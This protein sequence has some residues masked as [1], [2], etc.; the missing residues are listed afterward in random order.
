M[1]YVDDEWSIQQCVC[2]LMLLE[3][4][5]TGEEVARQIINTI[6]RELGMP[7]SSVIA[8][9]RDSASVNDVAMR[10]VLVE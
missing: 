7:S 6:S 10:T 1:Q 5:M 4:T 3:K 2:R 9:A 8:A